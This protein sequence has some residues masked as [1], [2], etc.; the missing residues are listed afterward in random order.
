MQPPPDDRAGRTRSW[1]RRMLGFAAGVAAVWLPL[2]MYAAT[3]TGW[4]F[5][6]AGAG[7]W[8]VL[9][10]AIRGF[11]APAFGYLGGVV[12]VVVLLAIVLSTWWRA[13]WVRVPTAPH[14]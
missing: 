1:Q 4:A 8:V 14:V 12:S 11:S 13:P 5:G 10:L 3:G 6:V 7:L 9:V 2:Q